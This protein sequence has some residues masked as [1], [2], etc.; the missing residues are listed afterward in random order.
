[1]GI[2]T[3]I[4]LTLLIYA[5]S[6]KAQ[7]LTHHPSVGFVMFVILCVCVATILYERAKR[8][9]DKTGRCI[10]TLGIEAYVF[11]IMVLGELTLPLVDRLLFN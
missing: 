8:K 10:Y 3:F 4:I 1:M 6:G 2:G 5:C 9:D 7:I 11:V